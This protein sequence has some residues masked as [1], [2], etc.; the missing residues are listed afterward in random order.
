MT[1][2][3]VE[4]IKL[5]QNIKYKFSR[6]KSL[7]LIDNRPDKNV[8]TLTYKGEPVE[9]KFTNENVK[10]YIESWFADD[11]KTRG[12]NDIALLLEEI[13]INEYK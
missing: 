2:Q 8:G 4:F 9:I 10:N 13:K 1:A 6:T 12:N 7:T 3:K 11:N 5:S